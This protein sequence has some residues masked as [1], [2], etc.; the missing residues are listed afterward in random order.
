MVPEGLRRELVRLRLIEQAGPAYLLGLAK[1]LRFDA[2]VPNSATWAERLLERLVA[3]DYT[4]AWYTLGRWRLA[5]AHTEQE[6]RR[7]WRN[8][9]LAAGRRHPPAMLDVAHRIRRG[10]CFEWRDYRAYLAFLEAREEGMNVESELERLEACL[11]LAL[12]RIARDSNIFPL[13]I[14]APDAKP[15]RRVPQVVLD[16]PQKDCNR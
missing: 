4:P 5:T 13:Y 16:R 14:E 10:P 3:D 2:S 15:D 8:I 12:S 1:R 6:R 7:A 9:E 11:G